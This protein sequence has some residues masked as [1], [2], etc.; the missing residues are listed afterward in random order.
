MIVIFSGFNQRA[1]I[2]FLRT[3]KKNRVDNYRIVAVSEQDSIFQTAYKDKVAYVRKKKQLCIQEFI[4]A[5]KCIIKDCGEEKCLIAPST[6]ALNR[7]ML[8]NRSTLEE[9]KCIIPL[10]EKNLY[11]KVSDK[12]AFGKLCYCKGLDTPK[13][14]TIRQLY[15]GPIV[16]KPRT[17]FSSEGKVFSPVIIQSKEQH[18]EFKRQY[19]TKD[20][21]YQEYIDGES[22]YLLYYFTKEGEAYSF[23]QINYAQQPGG[24]SILVAECSD[25]HYKEE[26]SDKYKMLFLELGFF[27][28]VMVELRENN[29]IFYMIEANPR[30]WGPAQLFC[31]AG[32]NLFEIF[33]GEYGYIE[34]KKLDQINYQAKYLWSGGFEGNVYQNKQCVWLGNGKEKVCQDIDLFMKS[35][36]YNREDTMDVFYQERGI[37]HG[38]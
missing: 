38:K 21:I 20:F 22:Y 18:K 23:S 7:F 29:G 9:N 2:A 15:S 4:D 1:V 13:L 8:E 14:V 16:A 3:L 30:F 6:E 11:E 24:K 17:Y 28:F 37:N 10:V 19:N 34:T 26:I 32:Y 12:E 27:G 25:V 36:L 35:D 31:D 5:I 33:L